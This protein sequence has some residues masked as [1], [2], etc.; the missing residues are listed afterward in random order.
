MSL[1]CWTGQYSTERAGCHDPHETSIVGLRPLVGQGARLMS[2]P[3]ARQMRT[4]GLS[5]IR[6]VGQL[7][8][9]NDGE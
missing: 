3:M 8:Q 1:R 2:R 5:N 7:G 4:V 6:V 9:M